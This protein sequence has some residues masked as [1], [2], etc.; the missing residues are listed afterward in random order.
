M[1]EGH[2]KFIHTSVIILTFFGF[3]MII[4]ATANVNSSGAGNLLKV[5]FKELF[6]IVTSYILMVWVARRFSLKKLERYYIPLLYGTIFMLIATMFF[7]AVGGAKAWIRFG[8]LFT[9]QPSEFAKV[10]VILILAQSLGDRNKMKESFSDI[11]SHPILMIMFIGLFVLVLQHDFGTAAIIFLIALMTLMIFANTTLRKAQLLLLVVFVFLLGFIFAINMSSVVAAIDKIPFPE[12]MHYMIDRIRVSANPFLDKHDA[13]AQIFNGLAAFVS[14]GLWG[15]GY[16]KGFLKYSF[17]Y[18][19]ESDSIL[20]IIIEE[21]GVI[22]GFLPIIV[23]YG[24]IMFQLMKYVFI[25]KLDKD[26]AI[27]MGTLSYF[28]I[29]FLFNVGGISAAIPLTGIPLLFIS[30]GG[31]SRL[32]IMIAIG[33]SQNV[34]ARHNQRLARE[35]L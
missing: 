26:K 11:A 3:A 12:R 32:A 15:V 28:F 18:A 8:G 2:S 16:G 31:S 4:S 30:A 7:P 29:H 9:I 1:P 33:L 6:F 23:F 25:V 19:A 5:I 27:L 24:L 35:T 20:A 13:G 17:I 21:M 34:I 22:F 10:M 14:G